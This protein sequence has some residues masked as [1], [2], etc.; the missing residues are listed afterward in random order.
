MG[1]IK[2]MLNGSKSLLVS[3]EWYCKCKLTEIWSWVR[4]KGHYHV[5]SHKGFKTQQ[6]SFLVFGKNHLRP[7]IRVILR[8]LNKQANI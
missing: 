4:L 6:G 1:E 2:L 8:L 7:F 3:F 5:T